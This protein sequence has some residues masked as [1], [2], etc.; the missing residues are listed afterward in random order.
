MFWKCSFQRVYRRI[1]GSA[2]S[3]GVR[4]WRRVTNRFAEPS[5]AAPSLGVETRN[6]RLADHPEVGWATQYKRV[7]RY[8]RRRENGVRF[9]DTMAPL[10]MSFSL[11][12]GR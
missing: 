10:I 5:V 3:K 6:F 1:S 9:R 2:D 11:E 8:W 7:Y 4:E 12:C